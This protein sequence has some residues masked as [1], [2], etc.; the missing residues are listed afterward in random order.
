MTEQPTTGRGRRWMPTGSDRRWPLVFRS[1][2][3]SLQ[4]PRLLMG[5]IAIVVFMASGAV[6]DAVSPARVTVDGVAHPYDQDE[7]QSLLRA[8]VGLWAHGPLEGAKGEALLQQ[9]QV[10]AA[11]V[12]AAI[13]DRYHARK[14]TLT[15]KLLGEDDQEQR[16]RLVE[17]FSRDEKEAANALRNLKHFES[18]GVFES[19]VDALL[20]AA[21]MP[22]QG[23]WS[24]SPPTFWASIRGSVA[25]V[26][27][28]AGALWTHHRVF[29]LVFG[30]I[31]LL[32][33]AVA[34]GAISRLTAMDMLSGRASST[35]EGLGY[36]LARARDTLMGL[37]FFPLVAVVLGLIVVVIGGVLLRFPIANIAGAV[38]YGI[39]LL[40]GLLI[41]LIGVGY[42]GCMSLMVPAVAV[43]ET[44]G[45]DA[46]Q[47]AYA[48]L[49]AKPGH[50]LLYTLLAAV[51]GVI[52]LTLIWLIA[53]ATLG[54][55]A[56]L[57]SVIGGE[58]VATMAGGV[59]GLT[60]KP[61]LWT[62]SGTQQVAGGIISV[63][64]SIVAGLV[65]AFVV[66]FYFTS[67]TIIYLLMRWAVDGQAVEE[68]IPGRS[69][70]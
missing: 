34:G 2:G 65:G 63:W 68:H 3:Q 12:R 22:V 31:L 49:L 69:E 15:L 25:A 30:L 62:L 66:S 36:A 13:V 11:E 19:T 54:V 27:D 37:V 7:I 6:W 5:L 32:V 8:N 18:H 10:T 70:A 28:T 50:L 64:R 44:D 58:S 52:A 1:L 21:A 55:T 4:G 51:Q 14:D 42:A 59:A 45:Y 24:L 41:V 29:V 16:D 9:E 38:V 56:D 60:D 67:Q 35:V 43:D 57:A 61:E 46:Q 48:Y 47:R 23:F 26:A 20:N 40:L 39:L 17:R 33:W 53:R